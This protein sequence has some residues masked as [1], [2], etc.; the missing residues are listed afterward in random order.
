MR[1]CHQQNSTSRSRKKNQKVF[2]NREPAHLQESMTTKPNIGRLLTKIAIAM[3]IIVEVGR[4]CLKAS[5][6]PKRSTKP[7]DGLTSAAFDL[8]CSKGITFRKARQELELSEATR[9][10]EADA[11]GKRTYKPL[12]KRAWEAALNFL[13]PALSP[14]A[15]V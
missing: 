6:Q 15:R 4:R 14:R 12:L 10:S 8:A 1:S 11:Q 3:P 2:G 7:A 13:G 5:R 9:K